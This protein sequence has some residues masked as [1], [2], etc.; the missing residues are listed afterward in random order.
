[1]IENLEKN[2]N[3]ITEKPVENKNEIAYYR[4][5]FWKRVFAA[6]FDFL[7]FFFLTTALFVGFKEFAN[8]FTPIKKENDTINRLRLESDIF[9]KNDNRIIDIVTYYNGSTNVSYAAK[10]IDLQKRLNNFFIFIKENSNDEVYE[11][12]FKE[13]EEYL[14]SSDF[15][16]E[17]KPYFIRNSDGKITKNWD[18]KIPSKNYVEIVYSPYI[19]KYTQ[20]ILVTK[21]PEYLEAQKKIS[22]VLLF[23]EVP[24]A[25]LVSGLI[26]Y[27]AIPLIFSRGK[28]TLG[29]FLFKI[30]LV[31][32]NVLSVSVKQYTLRFLIFIFLEV[33]LSLVTIGVPIIISFSMMVFSKKKQ[34]FHDYMLEIEEVDVENSKIYK[35]YDEIY[36]K[37]AEVEFKDF[38]LI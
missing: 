15:N 20:G 30:G 28:Q 22:Y 33:F 24:L 13:Y 8:Q 14:L 1:M 3:E 10:E 2:Q 4:P 11:T 36:L 35:S 7:I 31:N 25:L 5:K 21:I 6:I 16:Y 26:I 18:A 38:N 23:A 12:S 19:D 27:Y 9:L 37:P 17:G 32:K 34:S 29:K